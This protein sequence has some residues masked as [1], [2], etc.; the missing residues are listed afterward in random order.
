[1]LLKEEVGEEVLPKEV[2][3]V[4]AE[5]MAETVPE[6]EI[7][8]QA[9]P[10]QE[11]GAAKATARK[12]EQRI[13]K[14]ETLR[15]VPEE[16]VG[17]AML[18]A[19]LRQT[20]IG[21]EKGLPAVLKAEVQRLQEAEGHQVMP[22][23]LERHQAILKKAVRRRAAM[24]RREITVRSALSPGAVKVKIQ[25]RGTIA[26]EIHPL[27]ALQRE[28]PETTIGKEAAALLQ[29]IRRLSG[30]EA[31]TEPMGEAILETAVAEMMV[32]HRIVTGVI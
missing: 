32:R 22:A 23:E 8:L 26:E 14:P 21:A 25:H 19:A 15:A 30:A 6:A 10:A 7:N 11:E 18:P 24:G 13:K 29:V 3:P 31:E 9:A 12:K 20:I 1:M 28:Q 27:A 16:N 17:A 4:K 5:V 2:V